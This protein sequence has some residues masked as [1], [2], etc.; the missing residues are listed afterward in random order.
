MRV[1]FSVNPVFRIHHSL[2]ETR[3]RARLHTALRMWVSQDAAGFLPFSVQV[4]E[5]NLQSK[6]ESCRHMLAAAGIILSALTSVCLSARW[7]PVFN[8]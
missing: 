8:S 4:Q 3:T 2:N 5:R 7:R 6:Q 1:A